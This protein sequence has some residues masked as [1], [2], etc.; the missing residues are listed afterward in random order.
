MKTIYQSNA[1]TADIVE[2]CIADYNSKD[3]YQTNTM[4]KAQPGKSLMLLPDT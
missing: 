3:Q 2:Q 1:V 4:N